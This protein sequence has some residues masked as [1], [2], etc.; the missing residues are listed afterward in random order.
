MNR[1]RLSSIKEGPKAQSFWKSI[2]CIAPVY[3]DDSDEDYVVG[4]NNGS[5]QNKKSNDGKN[6]SDDS[7]EDD[8]SDEHEEV[9]EDEDEEEEE[10]ESDDESEDC[11][12]EDAITNGEESEDD[13]DDL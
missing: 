9:D 13:L 3:R 8:D 12:S 2:F 4:S 5:S 1:S 11:G 10:E 6:E 7:S